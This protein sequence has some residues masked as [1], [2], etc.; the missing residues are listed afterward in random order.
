MATLYSH[1]NIRC[2]VSPTFGEGV[3]MNLIEASACGLMVMAT[4]WSE[5]INYLH[6]F[7]PLKY[8]LSEVQ[9]EFVDFKGT[10]Y[11]EGSKCAIVSTEHLMQ[12]MRGF[13]ELT[14]NT[15]RLVTSNGNYSNLSFESVGKKILKDLESVELPKRTFNVPDKVQVGCGNNPERG[16]FNIDTDDNLCS[17]CDMIMDVRNLTFPSKSIS[18]ILINQL[19]EHL[20][21]SDIVLALS[22]CFDVLKSGGELEIHTPNIEWAFKRYL[23]TGGLRTFEQNDRLTKMILGTNDNH[24]SLIGM[25]KMRFLLTICGFRDIKE[26]EY[27]DFMD[28][29]TRVVFEDDSIFVTFKLKALKP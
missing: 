11:P 28:K 6:N 17:Q 13:Y 16:Y 9:D 18:K 29:I 12:K 2:F 24:K 23:E 20:N 25:R 7:I 5:H 3:G 22:N 8:K 21:E 1:P 26:I 10:V 27:V 15:K 4:G 14:K 19:L